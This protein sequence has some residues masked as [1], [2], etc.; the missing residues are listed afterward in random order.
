[1]SAEIPDLRTLAAHAGLG[2]RLHSSMESD[3]EKLC[4][5][6][7]PPSLGTAASDYRRAKATYLASFSNGSHERELALNAFTVQEAHFLSPGR[8]RAEKLFA[9]VQFSPENTTINNLQSLREPMEELTGMLSPCKCVASDANARYLLKLGLGSFVRK[10]VNYF[11]SRLS[12]ESE[13]GDQDE[14]AQQERVVNVVGLILCF[15]V[16]TLVCTT[17]ENSADILCEDV[18]FVRAT[19]RCVMDPVVSTAAVMTLWNCLESYDHQVNK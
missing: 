8:R 10:A 9:T 11:T 16:A 13:H 5:L 18:E 12:T 7:L 14:T 3:I 1:M 4:H 17:P 2:T 6:Y 19:V 15:N